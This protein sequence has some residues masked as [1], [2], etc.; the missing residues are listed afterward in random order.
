MAKIIFTITY[1]IVP[2]ARP[3]YLSLVEEMKLY[4]LNVQKRNYNVYEKKGKKNTFTEIFLCESEEEFE[5]L[6]DT[7]DEQWQELLRR[8]QEYVL[9]GKTQYSTYIEP[10]E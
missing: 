5:T 10:I 4:F 8:V 6:E 1:D 3:A 2:A 9:E 7:M